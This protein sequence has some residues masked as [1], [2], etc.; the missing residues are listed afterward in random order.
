MMNYRNKYI[1][2]KTKYIDL[3]MQFGGNRCLFI[4][5]NGGGATKDMWY[6]F[7]GSKTNI[8]DKVSKLGDI[9]IYNPITTITKDILKKFK[10]N[11][12]D[13]IFTMADI[14]FV[15]H[16]KNLYNEVS[17]KHTKFFLI[18]HSRGYMYANIFASLYSK[19]ILG[20]I[21]IDGG[22]PLEE[23]KLYLKDNKNK[24]DNITDKML[25]DY[26]KE[27]KLSNSKKTK[28]LV[29]LLSNIVTYYQYKQ[30]KKTIIKY[31]FPTYI[32]NN[33]Y[34]D[35][36]V[37]ITM[38]DYVN[39]TLKWKFDYNKEVSN[40]KNVKHIWYVG[41]KHWLFVYPDVE[42]DIIGIIT[43]ILEK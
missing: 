38:N 16:S 20:Y 14:D 11:N 33:I 4:F 8:L 31:N 42:N 28:E 5:F 26:Q 15:K 9:Y 40:N 21:N 24:Y 29:K 35:D 36:E 7:Q 37:N 2:Y 27:L 19:H 13:F 30:Y 12:D 43:K 6:E 25:L 17:E 41:K 34:D 18:S 39:T 22:K 1:K 10:K 32:L 23:Y 3:F